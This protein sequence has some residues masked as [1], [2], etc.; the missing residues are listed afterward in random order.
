MEFPVVLNFFGMRMPL[1]MLTEIAAFFLGYRYFVFLKRKK[2][3]PFDSEQRLILLI[4]AALGALIFSRVLGALENV[5][6]WKG[7]RNSWEYLY[8][9]KTVVG[10][11]LGGWFAVEC[12]KKLLKLKQSSGDLMVYPM[13]F[14]LII[15]RIGC[16]SQGVYEET[17]GNETTW[18][19]GINL[20]D[21]KFRHP[22]A[23]YE[24]VWAVLIWILLRVLERRSELQDGLR[25]KLFMF[26]YLLY[27]YVAEYYKPGHPLIWNQTSIQLAILLTYAI[28]FKLIARLI[29]KPEFTLYGK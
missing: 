19:T 20:G 22:L 24:I 10:G 17:Y 18:L 4:A 12:A 14:A 11:F 5:T 23:L 26:L 29:S 9:N 1:H 3:D 15:G 16:F 7:A 13:L 25:F 6:A 28:Y 27:R 2:A 21:G 8:L